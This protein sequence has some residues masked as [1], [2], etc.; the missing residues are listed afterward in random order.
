[1]WRAFF[2]LSKNRRSGTSD[3]EKKSTTKGI[4]MIKDYMKL[5]GFNG[6]VKL[7]SL[8]VVVGQIQ[9]LGWKCSSTE[10]WHQ[11]WWLYVLPFLLLMANWTEV[12]ITLWAEATQN[13]FFFLIYFNQVFLRW[14][15]EQLT[16]TCWWRITKR[17]TYL[18]F[19]KSSSTLFDTHVV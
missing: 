12:N 17:K 5:Y 19:L 1:M 4:T 7:P 16:I 15:V 3:H 6:V 10:Y 13:V 9:N 14:S 8:T 18:R 2:W 11:S